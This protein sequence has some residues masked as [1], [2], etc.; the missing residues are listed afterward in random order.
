[1]SGTRQEQAQF[2]LVAKPGSHLVAGQ[3]V[4]RP[5]RGKLSELGGGQRMSRLSEEGMFGE[6]GGRVAAGL[7]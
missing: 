6:G 1:M 5:L 4:Q 2:Y 7:Y 3:G